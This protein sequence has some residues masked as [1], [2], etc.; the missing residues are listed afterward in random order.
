MLH[1]LTVGRRAESVTTWAEV[2][3]DGPTGGK[4]LVGAA[5][6]FDSLHPLLP[7]AGGM[8]GVLRTIIQIPLLPMVDTREEFSLGGSLALELVGHDYARDG[9]QALEQ[10]AEELLGSLLISVALTKI[11]RMFPS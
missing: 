8:V 6:G 5:R 2:L 1:F 4:E 7:L 10:L 3:R 11:S 9:G